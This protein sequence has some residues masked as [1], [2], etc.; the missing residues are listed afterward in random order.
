MK[1]L[2]RPLLV[3]MVEQTSD[4]TLSHS[5]YS[6]VFRQ[7]VIMVCT[8]NGQKGEYGE[9]RRRVS[10]EMM[11]DFRAAKAINTGSASSWWFTKASSV[12]V[13]ESGVWM[14][15]RKTSAHKRDIMERNRGSTLVCL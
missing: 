14:V 1:T 12:P 13:G 6:E 7:H 3:L 15:E 8:E 5:K 4:I 2:Q 11:V 9:R 10:K